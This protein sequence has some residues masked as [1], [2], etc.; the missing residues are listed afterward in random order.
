MFWNVIRSLNVLNVDGVTI[1]LAETV[2]G[3]L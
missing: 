1:I 2:R 3:T